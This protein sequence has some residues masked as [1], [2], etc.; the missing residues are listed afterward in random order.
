MRLYSNSFSSLVELRP[1]GPCITTQVQ[2]IG[3]DEWHR[4]Y[5]IQMTQKFNIES[6]IAEHLS[7]SYGTQANT[8][9]QDV[10]YRQRLSPKYP[11]LESEV[12]Y[13][14]DYELATT[15]VDVLARRLRLAFLDAKEALSCSNRVIEL[16]G[17]KL[18]WSLERREQEM[19]E[20]KAFLK[21]M[22]L[23]LL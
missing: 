9:L 5:S 19:R 23:D 15:T 14:C 2:L 3:S 10:Q 12:M 20:T 8:I 1:Q 6:E 21:T 4:N 13:A 17:D 22:G 18:G 16:M 11:Y 7:K